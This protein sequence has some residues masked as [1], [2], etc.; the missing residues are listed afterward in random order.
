[1]KLYKEGLRRSLFLA[2]LFIAIM[3]LGA[4]L[5]PIANITS[6]IRAVQNGWSAGR[7]VMDGFGGNFTLFLAMIAFAPFITLFLFS[8]LNKR[9]ASDFFHSLPHKRE[10]IFVSYT[11]A[12]LTWVLGGLWLSTIISI[13]IYTIGSAYILIN[14]S[15][16][17]LVTLAL[18]AGCL[19]VM[20]ATLMAMSVTGGLFANITTA[21]LILFLPRLISF[22]FTQLVID[23]ARVVTMANFGI[24]GDVSYNIPFMFLFNLLDMHFLNVETALIRGIPY[25]G[26]LGLIYLVVALVLFKRRR[27]ET[28]GNPAQSGMLQNIIRIAVAFTVCI[29]PIALILVGLHSWEFLLIVA[30]YGVAVVVYFAYELIT[31]RKLSNIVKALPGL[32]ILVLLNILF[33]TGVNVSQN[34]IL[35]RTIDAAQVQSVRILSFNYW[36]HH[37]NELSYEELRLRDLSISDPR[38][39]EIL[40]GSLEHDLGIAQGESEPWQ[41]TTIRTRVSFELH[42][43]RQIERVIGVF[44]RDRLA[45]T[46]ILAEQPAYVSIFTELPENPDDVH[47]WWGLS[48]EMTRELYNLFREEV[49]TVDF[50]SWRT[51]MRGHFWTAQQDLN[52]YGEFVVRGFVGLQPFTSIYP[53]TDLTPRTLDLFLTHMNA[54]S[55]TDAEQAMSLTVDTD[56]VWYWISVT[57]YGQTNDTWL[58]LDSHSGRDNRELLTLLRDA[59]LAQGDRPVDR[60]LPYFSIQFNVDTEQ[61]SHHVS[62]HGNFF[63][64][65][66]AESLEILAQE[67]EHRIHPHW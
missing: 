58:H 32:G 51:A 16:M 19:L 48:D 13:V 34:I 56:R 2:A 46:E 7:I 1:M 18:S 23:G 26:I 28:A 36:T 45:L 22:V 59:V 21:L 15:T 14:I 29:V 35:N 52:F 55:R 37:N 6:Q 40:I 47:L 10:T 41:G 25:T 61:D 65:V 42:S 8:F 64:N 31:S 39:V 63:F 54:I 53:L 43:G 57:G 24:L 67:S 44:D 11:A 50:V 27:S 38:A 62:L 9:N 5:I 30:L 49:P 3:K 66:D 60:S 33:I 17:L 4:I 12:A 20:A